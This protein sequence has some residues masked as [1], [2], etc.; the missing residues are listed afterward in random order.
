MKYE[1]YSIL[2]ISINKYAGINVIIDKN[3]I[4]K[5]EININSL[6]LTKKG[7]ISYLIWKERA[8]DLELGNSTV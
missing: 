1:K 3:V 2:T 8:L 4:I 5:N 7:F 6:I